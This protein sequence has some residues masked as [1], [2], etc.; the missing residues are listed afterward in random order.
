MHVVYLL[1]CVC[2]Q[3]LTIIINLEAE[4]ILH[5]CSL[6]EEVRVW[7]EDEYKILL[8]GAPRVGKTSLVRRYVEEVFDERTRFLRTGEN[9]R[10]VEVDGEPM[11][12]SLYD[13]HGM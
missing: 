1:L 11:V 13:T 2:F 3:S 12:L 5:V 9:K 10:T 8:I 6:T 4:L 7:P